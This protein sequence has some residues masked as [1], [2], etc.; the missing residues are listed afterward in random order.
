[1]LKK[2]LLACL[3]MCFTF[4]AT[5]S[6]AVSIKDIGSFYVGGK[7]IVL[8]GLQTSEVQYVPGGPMMKIDPNGE[9][10]AFQMY[11][12]YIK[13]EKPKAKYP[14]L[15]WHGGGLSGVTWETT[16]DGRPGW[17]WIFCQAGNDVYISD[18]VERGRATWA[19]YPEINPGPPVFRNPKQAWE[20]FRIGPKYD[21]DPTKRVLYPD[22]QFPVEAFEVFMKQSTPRWTSS[23]K[24]TQTAYD[25]LLKMF[26]GGAVIMSHS[27]GCGFAWQA[28]M[29]APQSVKALIVVEPATFPAK[30]V[31][32]SALK[33]IPVLFLYGDINT[34]YWK[35]RRDWGADFRK[36]LTAQGND[37]TWIELTDK[38]FKGNSHMLMMDKNNDKSAQLILD[39]MK[40]KNLLK[41]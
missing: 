41:K 32:I 38:G 12:E 26:A 27:Q 9:Y 17:E 31:D 21:P 39:W 40:E 34:D 36:R 6:A 7:K 10:I 37:V 35:A 24:P 29:N 16:P 8:E 15:M 18:A 3:V 4:S 1:M 20:S 11:V 25:E 30:E 5:S 33:G 23:D 22:T 19:R 13:L 14:M 2:I 28:A